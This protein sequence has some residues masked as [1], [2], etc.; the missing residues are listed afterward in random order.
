[1]EVKDR[2]LFRRRSGGIKLEAAR[3]GGRR[4]GQE[5][6][7]QS[8]VGPVLPD[9]PGAVSEAGRYTRGTGYVTPLDSSPALTRWIW[10]GSRCAPA[11]HDGRG[12]PGP[13]SSAGVWRPWR[14]VC[15]SSHGDAAG[16]EPGA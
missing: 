10:A 7:R 11:F 16:A 4:E 1:M 3:P 6:P 12:T 13:V 8:R 14:R 9:G 15:E 5:Q 2:P